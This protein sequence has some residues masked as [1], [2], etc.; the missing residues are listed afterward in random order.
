MIEGYLCNETDLNLQPVGYN[1]R[2]ALAHKVPGILS[3]YH[4]YASAPIVFWG[5]K[6]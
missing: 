6:Q 2:K 4:N 5:S 3:N 1:S